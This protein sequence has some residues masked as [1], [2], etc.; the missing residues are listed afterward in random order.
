MIPE[1]FIWL[2]LA[3]VGGVG[4]ISP[5]KRGGGGCLVVCQFG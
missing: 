3:D 5:L 4:G 2:R 1:I